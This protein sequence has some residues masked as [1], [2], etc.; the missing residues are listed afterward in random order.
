MINQNANTMPPKTKMPIEF[1]CIDFNAS[2]YKDDNFV[3]KMYGIDEKRKTYF[4]KIDDFKP[5]L[6]I[7]VDDIGVTQLLK[8]SWNI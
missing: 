6:Y 8:I 5:F 7:K 2:D 4:V 3:I 1:R